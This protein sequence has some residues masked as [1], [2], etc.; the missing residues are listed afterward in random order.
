[1]M[2]WT[3]KNYVILFKTPTRMNWNNVMCANRVFLEYLF[4]RIPTA[5][6]AFA[7]P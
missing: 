4:G 3:K 6:L 7:R 2:I 1:M 5:Y